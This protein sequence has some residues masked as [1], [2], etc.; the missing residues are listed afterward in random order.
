MNEELAQ[1]L[2][3]VRRWLDINLMGW[4]QPRM[5]NIERALRNATPV[6]SE[7]GAAD[8]GDR[9]SPADERHRV[10]PAVAASSGVLAETRRAA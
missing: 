1:D 2:A 9:Q 5:D 3:E 8:T 7:S 6:G 10:R 4:L